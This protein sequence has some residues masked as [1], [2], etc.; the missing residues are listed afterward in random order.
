MNP[1]AIT[2]DVPDA[3]RFLWHKSHLSV[4]QVFVGAHLP[5][6]AGS[7]SRLMF[8]LH[9]NGW[10]DEAAGLSAWIM[11]DVRTLLSCACCRFGLILYSVTVPLSSFAT[12][13][14]LDIG[15]APHDFATVSCPS[16]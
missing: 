13:T 3:E 8:L 9:G 12:T 11:P 7:W 1:L 14:T 6:A 16:L 10:H 4:D 2:Y 15:A 5:T